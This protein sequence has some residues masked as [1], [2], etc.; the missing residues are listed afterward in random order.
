M[1]RT[2]GVTDKTSGITVPDDVYK[3]EVVALD[4]KQIEFDGVLQDKVEFTF[5]IID[6]QDYEGVELRGLASLPARLTPKSKLRQWAQ[7][8]LGREFAEGDSLDLDTLLG[9]QCRISTTTV[10]G[11]KGGQFTN[12]K[13][14]LMARAARGAQKPLPTNGDQGANY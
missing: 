14:V 1:G 2:I 6:D 13:D 7:A 12:V 11:K 9:R 5:R 3:A 8:I 10:E 4:E